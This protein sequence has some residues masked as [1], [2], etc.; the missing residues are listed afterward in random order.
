M[1]EEPLV[2]TAA[3]LFQEL[4]YSYRSSLTAGIIVAGWDRRKGGQVSQ[5]ISEDLVLSI[6][7]SNSVCYRLNIY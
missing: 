3:K 1:N 2:E 7:Q 5:Y 6:F 4:I